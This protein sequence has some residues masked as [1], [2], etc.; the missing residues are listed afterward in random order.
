LSRRGGGSWKGKKP[1]LQGGTEKKSAKVFRAE[2]DVEGTEIRDEKKVVAQFGEEK[3]KGSLLKLRQAKKK[4]ARRRMLR[5][6]ALRK[7]TS[8]GS[9]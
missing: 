7:T 3:C 8:H 2:L 9:A 6:E 4:R 1:Q 5:K